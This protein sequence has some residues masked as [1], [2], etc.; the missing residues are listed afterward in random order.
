MGRN[1]TRS[2]PL[3]TP[4]STRTMREEPAFS[5]IRSTSMT[6]EKAPKKAAR[7]ESFT[8]SP[9][10]SRALHAA[11]KNPAPELTPMILGAARGL[12]STP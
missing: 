10:G 3:R 8:A 9:A 6:Q 11:T 5:A 4:A 2:V 7:G 1:R 12:F